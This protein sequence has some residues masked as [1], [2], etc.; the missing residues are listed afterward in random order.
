MSIMPY[1]W[2][3]SCTASTWFIMKANH[4]YTAKVK[5]NLFG[6]NFHNFKFVQV[7]S[8]EPGPFSCPE[9]LHYAMFDQE[10]L[11]WLATFLWLAAFLLCQGVHISS[12]VWSRSNLGG[13]VVPKV[14]WNYSKHLNNMRRLTKKRNARSMYMAAMMKNIAPGNVAS[15]SL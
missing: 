6:D 1:L 9:T 13:G 11:L 5:Q 15:V 2:N 4:Q 12:L 8:D 10:T 3:L 14:L 7:L